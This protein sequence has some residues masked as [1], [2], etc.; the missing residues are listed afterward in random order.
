MRVLVIED[1]EE[2]AEAIAFGLRQTGMAVDV[3]LDGPAGFARSSV[4]DYD[5]IVL[6]RDLPGMHGDELCAKLVDSECRSRVLMLTAAAMVEDLVDGLGLGADDYLP[7]PFD[8][9][10]LVA[11]IGALTRRA[12]P[13]IPPLLRHEDLV[14][15]TAQHR[16]FRA[17]RE[18]ELAP[19][20]FG[21][22]EL[23]LAA[24]GPQRVGRGAPR[25]RVG[26]GRG[27]VHERGQDHDQPPALK[28]RR[29]PDHRD[30]R[31]VR[32]PDL[33]AAVRFGRQRTCSARRLHLPR[34]TIRLRLALLYGGVFFISGA[35]LLALIYTAVARTHG[36]ILA[37]P[38]QRR[39]IV[40]LE[41]PSRAVSP[42][43]Q[44]PAGC[45]IRQHA[46]GSRQIVDPDQ[47]SADLRVLAIVS[48][49][50]LAV[51]AAV[52]MGLGWLIAGRVLRPLRTI[53][54]RRPRH[55]SH[56]PAPA[57]RARRA[58][59]RVQGARRHLRRA[60]RA[61]RRVLP[62]PA[63]VRRQRLARA[64]H[65]ARAA[66]DPGAGR[67]G[68]SQRH[69]GVTARRP[70]TGARLRAAARG[71]DRGAAQPRQQRA[72]PRPARAGRPDG[73]DRAGARRSPSRDRAP[74][75]ASE[76]HA[77]PCRGGRQPAARRASRG[78]PASTTRSRT[79]WPAVASTSRPRPTAGQAVL[80]VAN[81]GPVIAP[82]RAGPPPASPSSDSGPRAPTTATGTA[83]GSRS[84]TPIATAHGAT[85]S[86]HSQAAGG[87]HVTVRFPNPS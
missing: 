68:G 2:M 4:N 82:E 17:G 7:K 85:L 33:S 56:E 12:Q 39:L 20:E 61:A 11:R 65:P 69:A 44:L 42:C 55:I 49:I 15:D 22:L 23:L 48:V 83:S 5:V 28:A 3:A 36:A 35:V 60:A 40:T 25:P 70:R 8:F 14:L 74:R 24:A 58:R 67:A 81:D 79:T 10:V 86:V 76:R 64:A 43:S 21:V 6:D 72:G 78:E 34:R 63:P 62:I 59:R 77:R 71:A 73:G 50:A 9:P 87:L 52:S 66:Q 46:S 57:A 13:A 1:D 38:S 18:I 37:G 84:S 54:T 53:T 30:G 47:R 27:P 26:R 16:V 31:Q 45:P 51:M 29:S 32:L 80:S 19:K 75:P 41:L